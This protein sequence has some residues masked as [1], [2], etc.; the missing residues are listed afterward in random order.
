M[1][2]NMFVK[3][4]IYFNSRLVPQ[5]KLFNESELAGL[6]K[7]Y[8]LKSGKKKS[9]AADELGVARPTI[10]LAEE[11]PEQSLTALRRRMIEA[12]SPYEVEGPVYFLKR[13]K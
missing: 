1:Q 2:E 3:C 11:N 10:Q 4:L 5:Q 8:R 9:E 13:K 12:Y 6:A 7:T